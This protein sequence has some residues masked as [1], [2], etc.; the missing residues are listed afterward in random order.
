MADLTELGIEQHG[1]LRVKDD[2]GVELAAQQHVM[3]LKANEVGKAA[4]SF[5]VFLSRVQ[6]TGRLAL[7]A[8]CGLEAGDNL[9][10]ENGRWTATYLPVLMKTFPLFLMTSS[11]DERGFVVGIDESSPAFS[12]ESGEALF[13]DNGKPSIYLSNVST[14]LESGVQDDIQTHHFL[15][16]LE[17]LS[18]HKSI[19]VLVHF[20]NGEVQTIKGLSTIDEDR[21]QS[22][23]AEQLFDLSAKGYLALIY[24]M[25][26]SIFQ[27]NLLIRRQN[28]K[29]DRTK[30]TQ[31]KLEVARDA[32]A[33]S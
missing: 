8:I 1:K 32:G 21:L 9:F 18:L 10:V 30:V 2:C 5:P 16:A 28:D 4:C 7:S 12:T 6:N 13:D 27:L 11:S 24:A 19:D 33:S 20:E 25:L 26:I 17:E 31:I 14:L 22:C 23:T 15:Q 29:G 3:G